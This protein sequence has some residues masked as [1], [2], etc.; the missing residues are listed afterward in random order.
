MAKTER[1]LVLFSQNV[2]YTG[3]E[4]VVNRCPENFL[5]HKDEWYYHLLFKIKTN[6]SCLCWCT[7]D[8][9][10]SH[11]MVCVSIYKPCDV[12]DYDKC[13]VS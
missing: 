12:T 5:T 13:A 9:Y 3:Y 4:R 7:C 1:K 2:N 6:S 11:Y 8:F 10:L